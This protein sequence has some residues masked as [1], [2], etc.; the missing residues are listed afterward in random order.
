MARV[1]IN[2]SAATKVGVQNA[3]YTYAADAEASDAY[4]ITLSPAPTAYA[5]GQKFIFKANTANTGA[6]TLN[7][8]SLGAKTL[9]KH[10]DQDLADNDIEAGSIVEVVYDGINFQVTSIIAATPGDVVGPSA[11]VD[12]ELPL[13]SG[14]GGKTLKRSTGTGVVRVDS[15]VVSIDS[16]VTD[17]VG[18]ASESAAGKVELATSA[19]VDTGTDTGRAIHPDGL[20]ESYAGKKVIEVVPFE[21]A[22]DVAVGDG[23]F[24]FTVPSTFN[25]MNLVAVHARVI[26]AGTTNSTT[27][28]I[29]NVTQ[30]A[31]MLTALLEIETGETGSDTSDPG[32]TI[33][34]NN[35]DVATNDLIR[36]DVDTVSTTAPKGLIVRMEFQLP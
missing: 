12:D 29:N 16:D 22:T 30:A 9:K 25:G 24:Y 36:I 1:P 4:A 35:D 10:T 20:A 2:S 5:A 8:N 3:S 6:A 33:D 7:V 23:A 14:T 34:T 13:F 19:E 11:S 32:P 26:T 28:Q 18:A 31:D 21:F 15:G 27:I 17:L